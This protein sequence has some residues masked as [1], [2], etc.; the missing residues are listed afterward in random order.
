MKR[1]RPEKR[2]RRSPEEA[3]AVILDA[4][5]AVFAEHLP[6]AVGLRDVADQAGVSHAL[7]THYFGTYSGL[8]EAAL[9]RRFMRLRESLV[10]RLLASLEGDAGVTELLRAYRQALT[11]NAQDPVTVRLATW[12]MMSGRVGQD[13]FFSH[14][15]QG[16]RMLADA[17]ESRT[18]IPRED[19]EFV[20][21][22]SFA[23][24]VTWTV[25]G[26]ALSGSF[27]KQRGKAADIA[28]EERTA[29]MIDAYL[30]RR[31]RAGAT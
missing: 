10:A 21:V 22:A 4:A 5:D 16:L 8:V 6:D 27:G 29:D 30:A 11:E 18:R 17:L 20:L 14:R 15:M 19:L 3:R 26:K 24:T 25:A 12:A 23:M 13:D 31:R 28:F 9:E 2:I 7:V 1:P